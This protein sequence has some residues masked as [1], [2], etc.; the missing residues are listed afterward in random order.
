MQNS[1]TT[2]IGVGHIVTVTID[3]NMKKGFVFRVLGN[4]NGKIYADGNTWTN[5]G[6]LRHATEEEKKQIK[7]SVLRSTK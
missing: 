4:I 2:K 3:D 6:N 1:N 5:E 7:T